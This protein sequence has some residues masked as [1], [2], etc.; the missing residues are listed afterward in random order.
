MEEIERVLQ[1]T[2]WLELKVKTREKD[3]LDTSVNRIDDKL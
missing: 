1:S 3:S 2:I